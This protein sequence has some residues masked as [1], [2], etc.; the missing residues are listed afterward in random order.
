[1]LYGSHTLSVVPEGDQLIQLLQAML[2]DKINKETSRRL[3]EEMIFNNFTAKEAQ[4]KILGNTTPEITEYLELAT[5]YKQKI[6]ESKN[7]ITSI[8]DALEGA[9]NNPQAPEALPT[10]RTPYP[11]DQRTIPTKV[12]WE[13]KTRRQVPR[14]IFKR[15]WRIPDKSR[16]CIMI[17]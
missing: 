3:L 4:L 13:E 6:L 8:L 14:R 9:Y 10:G 7:E 17:L 2:P 5:D 16:I 15:T 11:F 1:M 12:A